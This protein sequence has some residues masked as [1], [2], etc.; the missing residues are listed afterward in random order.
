MA[1]HNF[2]LNC[3]SKLKEDGIRI[4]PSDHCHHM[5]L[6]WEEKPC[7]VCEEVKRVLRLGSNLR[8][9]ING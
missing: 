2:C 4:Y 5:N 3:W 9:K 8:R 1:D 6:S 7:P